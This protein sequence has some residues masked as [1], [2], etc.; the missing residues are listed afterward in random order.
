MLALSK[1]LSEELFSIYPQKVINANLAECKNGHITKVY[2]GTTDELNNALYFTYDLHEQK[3][4]NQIQR[5]LL[6]DVDLKFL[7]SSRMILSFLSKTHYRTR[8]KEALKATIHQKLR[9]LEEIDLLTVSDFGKGQNLT[10][11]LKSIAF[12]IGQS[13]ALHQGKE[14]Y[15]KDE[16]AANFPDLKDYLYRKEIVNF[17]TLQT[18]LSKY[19]LI[20]KERSLEMLH[21]MEYT[22]EHINKI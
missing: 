12:Q 15:T 20:L 6:R 9:V 22:Y 19:N 4:D 16:I 11:T 10:D 7:R 1:K 8:I 5:L 13:I 14:L 3:F 17:I 21:L 2:K 18:W